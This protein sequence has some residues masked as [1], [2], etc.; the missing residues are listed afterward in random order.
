VDLIN[1]NLDYIG[2]KG[3]N[4][5]H[6]VAKVS[7]VGAGMANHPGVAAA[8]FEALAKEDIN[9]HMISTSEIKISCLVRKDETEKAVKAIHERFG[10]GETEE[11]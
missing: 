6:D 1:K 7:I 10:L 2:A 5:T 4:F 3:V 11:E 8:M 9:I